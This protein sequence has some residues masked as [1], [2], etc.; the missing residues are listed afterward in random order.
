MPSK[1]GLKQLLL[2]K[3]VQVSIASI[4][5]VNFIHPRIVR[6]KSDRNWHRGSIVGT[7]RFLTL[8]S[9]LLPTVPYASFLSLTYSF[10]RFVPLSNLQFLTLRS[11]L[12]PTVPYASFLS[13]SY[14]SLRFVPLSNI[15]GSLRFVLSLTCGCTPL[16]PLSNPRFLTLRSSLLP[17]AP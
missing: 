1:T 12:F 10:L 16:V 5:A 8:R 11:S 15:Y 3:P 14:G 6:V 9:S 17:T 7:P 4:T 13:L 2:V